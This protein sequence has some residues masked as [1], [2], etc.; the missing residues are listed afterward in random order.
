M[1]VGGAVVAGWSVEVGAAVGLAF[2]CDGRSRADC[3]EEEGVVVADLRACLDEAGGGGFEGL[4]VGG[5][6]EFEVVELR[7]VE[8]GPPLALEGGVGGLGGLPVPFL[9]ARRLHLFVVGGEGG[10]GLYVLRADHA[11]GESD[12][13]G[14]CERGS[15]KNRAKCGGLSTPAGPVEMTWSLGRSEKTVELRSMPTHRDRTA[16]NAAHDF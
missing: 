16:M 7:V 12:G 1:E 3:R 4:V 6:L 10:G 2:A 13:G 5:Y 9:V 15:L 8:E 14:C 11:P